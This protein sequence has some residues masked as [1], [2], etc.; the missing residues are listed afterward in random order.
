M[1]KCTQ[2]LYWRILSG[3][4]PEDEMGGMVWNRQYTYDLP[5]ID[6][7]LQLDNLCDPDHGVFS[8]LVAFRPC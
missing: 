7:T 5:R 6:Y 8:H 1:C 2:I 3:L 4:T